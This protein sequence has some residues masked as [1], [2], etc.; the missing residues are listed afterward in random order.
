M[1]NL[2]YN[3]CNTTAP[4]EVVRDYN[5][6][7][8]HLSRLGI[9]FTKSSTFKSNSIFPIELFKV[10][11]DVETIFKNISADTINE[12]THTNSKVL[13]YFPYEGLDFSLYN[14][15]FA[16]L[17]EYFIKYNWSFKKYFVFNNVNVQNLYEE[18][19]NKNP[20]YLSVKFNQVF[21]Y[22]IFHSESF[23][24]IKRNTVTQTEK[25]KNFVSYNSKVR[26][27]RL[28]LVSELIRRNLIKDAFVSLIGTERG[29]A[30]TGVDYN[31]NL[32]IEIVS[33]LSLNIDIKNHCVEYC[34]NWS[35]LI[36]D[37]TADTV[38]DVSSDLNHYSSTYFSVITETGMGNPTRITEKVFKAIV[39]KHP[40]LIIGC[41]DSLK[42]LQQLGYKTFPSMFDERYDSI[43]TDV[44]RILLIIDE[45]EKFCNLSVDEKNN[46]LNSI[47][48]TLEHNYN[49]FINNFEFHR[50][51]L[52]NIMEEILND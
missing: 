18:F 51:E 26:A 5:T 7:P 3:P 32:L 20:K 9:S 22:C 49:L 34:K 31:L 28:F 27:H 41:K 40:F 46:R 29:F 23:F 6:L 19:L 35:P 21:F 17:H 14:N 33:N 10:N 30:D 48:D 47:I 24:T 1:L 13:F 38:D 36:L 8:S 37:K 44:D 50:A 25:T 52:K 12:I 15:W 39:N 45:I 16:S 11:L 42:Y 2:V 4:S 43:E